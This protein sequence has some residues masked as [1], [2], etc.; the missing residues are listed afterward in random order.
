MYTV[1][2][3]ILRFMLA[4]LA[5]LGSGQFATAADE[6]LAPERAFMLDARVLGER[7]VE[8]SFTVAPDYYLYGEQFKFQASAAVLGLA[9]IPAGKVKFDET[10]QKMVESHRGFVR[11]TLPVQQAP[12][13]FRLFVTSQGCADKGLCYP[14][15]TRELSVSLVGF[16]GDGSVR[17]LSLSEP[18][19]GVVESVYQDAD[20]AVSGDDISVA[21]R[22][23]RLWP[24][25]GVFFAAGLLLSFTPCVLPMLPILSSLIAGQGQ[26][27]SRWRGLALAA[28][29]S[30]GMALT[31]TAFG[32]AAGLAGEGL[33]AALQTPWV[34]GGFALGLLLLAASM[35]GAYEL[36]LPSA[37]SGR[38]HKASQRLP[39]GRLVGVFAMGGVSALL[40]SPCIAAPLAGAL[41]YLSQSRDVTLGGTALFALAA[42]MSVPLLVLGASQGAL[43]PRAGAWMTDVK[44]FFGVLLI[45]VAIWTVQPVLPAALGLA[46]W[47]VLLVGCS[48]ALFRVHPTERKPWWRLV[49][50]TVM[51]LAGVLQLVG[52]ASGGSDPLR[53][54]AHLRGAGGASTH[55]VNF[56]P[57]LGVAELDTALRNAGRPVMLDF[58][59]DWCVSCKEMDRFTFSEPTVQAKLAGALL[60]RADVTGNT[61]RDRELL[62]RFQLFGPP[63]IIF[64]DA[65]GR[66]IPGTRVIGYE[67]SRRFAQTLQRAGL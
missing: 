44:R 64:F 12:R 22:G 40:V 2:N 58:Y 13:E 4:L 66:E 9:V 42:G 28:S 29:Y 54:L 16:G 10:F 43:L 25:M 7:E 47:G 17:M 50:A 21:L 23:G 27:V 11:I 60:L 46:L 30:L 33:A 34:L 20:N 15:M 24:V 26:V 65:Q 53:P 61:A 32:V 67:N 14:P 45:A 41:L 8:L 38:L 56:I 18:T 39:A 63:A 51:G 59:A 35:F 5:L 49:V 55:A 19:S 37:L 52:A 62:K 31:Y 3:F 6:F 48:V 57:I 1:L 36:Q